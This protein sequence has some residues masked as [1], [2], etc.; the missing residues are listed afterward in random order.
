MIVFIDGENFRQ[1]LSD[2][3]E[4]EKAIKIR[5]NRTSRRYSWRGRA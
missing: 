4:K 1:G 3:L 5:F 2:V